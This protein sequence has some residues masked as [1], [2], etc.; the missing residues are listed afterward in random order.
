M[1][2][3][4]PNPRTRLRANVGAIATGQTGDPP[5]PAEIIADP[6]ASEEWDRV[7]QDMRDRGV[8]SNA[9]GGMLRSI[10]WMWSKA[11][12]ARAEVGD[13]PYLLN[14]KD[15]PIEH[16]ASKAHA[17]YLQAH[18][19]ML[20]QVG[21]TPASAGRVAGPDAAEDK[22]ADLEAFLNARDTN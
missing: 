6:A 21:G 3:R 18:M 2:R 8:L 4:G 11:E 22:N 12:R 1:L 20:H 15:D 9:S 19:L 13:E 17:K 5:K 14:H 10:A 16:P 7:A